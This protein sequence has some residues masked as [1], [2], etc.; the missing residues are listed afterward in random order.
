M[1]RPADEAIIHAKMS[2][3]I[4]SFLLALAMTKAVDLT[5]RNTIRAT[6]VAT[7]A[8]ILIHSAE[9]IADMLTKSFLEGAT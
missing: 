7:L 1:L 6:V 8:L 2:V 4:A 5:L 9:V 3:F